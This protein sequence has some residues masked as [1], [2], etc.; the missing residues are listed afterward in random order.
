MSIT[1]AEFNNETPIH[2]LWLCGVGHPA[3]REHWHNTECE[4]DDQYC[5]FAELDILEKLWELEG[6][7]I[8]GWQNGLSFDE[9]IWEGGPM[10]TD[11]LGNSIY[12]IHARRKTREV[13][14]EQ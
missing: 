13:S 6:S 10:P 14:S 9:W 3:G 7:V 1:L 12:N 4:D 5:D 8:V 2:Y 11:E